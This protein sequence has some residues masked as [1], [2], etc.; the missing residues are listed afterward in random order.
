M[1]IVSTKGTSSL[2][3]LTTDQWI[4]SIVIFVERRGQELCVDNVMKAI[5]TQSEPLSCPLSDCKNDPLSQFG[6]LLWI[7]LEFVLLCIMLFAVLYFNID[8][9]SG[10]FNSYCMAECIQI[11][12]S[13][14]VYVYCRSHFWK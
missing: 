7:V 5:Q 14:P 1:H 2:R 10:P 4:N 13:F 9:L 11:V 3:F 8:F 12:N 6:W